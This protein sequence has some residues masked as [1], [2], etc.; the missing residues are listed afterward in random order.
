MRVT[1]GFAAA[2]ANAR[3]IA[4]AAVV[5]STASVWRP[6]A[7]RMATRPPV[8]SIHSRPGTVASTVSTP[9]VAP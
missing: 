4:L 3:S 6:A 9:V 8:S 2:I 5:S 7:L 1:R